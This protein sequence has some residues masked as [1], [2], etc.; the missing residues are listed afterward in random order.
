[1]NITLDFIL[2]I[3]KA[4]F[5]TPKTEW[6]CDF[7]ADSFCKAK[8]KNNLTLQKKVFNL[9]DKNIED[10]VKVVRSWISEDI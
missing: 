6:E 8:P 9:V 4:I 5:Y 7:H 1:M 3:A 10:T 2:G